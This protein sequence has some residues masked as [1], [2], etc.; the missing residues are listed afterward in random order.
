MRLPAIEFAINLASSE[1]TGYSPFFMNYGCLP[2]TMIWDSPRPTEY[3][4][5]RAYAMKMKHTV[6][7]VHDLIIAAQVKQTKDANKWCRPCP[8]QKGDL[9][10]LS[11]KNISFPKGLAR[12]FLPKFIGLYLVLEDF[13]NNSFRIDLPDQMKQRGIHNMFH[14]S[15]L[16]IHILNNNRLFPGRLDNQVAEFEDQERE[17][18]VEKI[19]SHKGNRSNAIFEV[20]WKAGDTTWLLYDQVDHLPTLQDYFD[21]LGIEDVSEL[22]EGNGAPP[23]DNPQVFLGGMGLTFSYKDSPSSRPPFSFN[24]QQPSL[25]LSNIS[26]NQYPL[27]FHALGNAH[28]EIVD[29]LRCHHLLI[30]SLDQLRLYLQHN[31]DLRGG[32]DPRSVCDGQTAP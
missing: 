25:T 12:K 18:A 13:R 11:T 10:Y 14:L 3:P 20:K 24:H 7:A 30:V 19:M 23:M 16:H 6:M 8:L 31:A 15:Y 28:F 22:T 2:R 5:V 32:A 27:L 26:S 21:V 4:G 1:G 9:V 29:R 17:W